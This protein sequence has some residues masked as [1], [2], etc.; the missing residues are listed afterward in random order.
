MELFVRTMAFLIEMNC[1][2]IA[3]II[4]IIIFTAYKIC[5]TSTINDNTGLDVENT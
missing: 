4:F 3:I 2:I 1:F 5:S